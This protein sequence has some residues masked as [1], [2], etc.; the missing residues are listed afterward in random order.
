MAAAKAVEGALEAWLVGEERDEDEAER[1][2]VEEEVVVVVAVG[3][4][5]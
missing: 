5:G 1:L 2:C 4:Q 3:D